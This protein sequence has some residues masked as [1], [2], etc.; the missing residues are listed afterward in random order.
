MNQL[1]LGQCNRTR[2]TLLVGAVDT[3]DRPGVACGR[4]SSV[5]RNGYGRRIVGSGGNSARIF[6]VGTADAVE[7]AIQDIA[8]ELFRVR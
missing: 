5:I 8:P 6:D 3:E 4:H 2:W 7:F 1:V